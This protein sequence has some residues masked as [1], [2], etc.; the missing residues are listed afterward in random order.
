MNLTV[1]WWMLGILFVIAC[2]ALSSHF[3]LIGRLRKQ[4]QRKQEDP[5][6]ARQAAEVMRK[7]DQGKT[8]GGI[9]LG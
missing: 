7:I 4:S 3:G 2:F 9:F 5:E 8:G 6:A 1:L